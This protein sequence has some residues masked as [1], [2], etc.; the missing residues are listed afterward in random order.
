[1]VEMSLDEIR[2]HRPAGDRSPGGTGSDAPPEDG[3]GPWSLWLG[4]GVRTDLAERLLSG[5][6]L[7]GRGRVQRELDDLADLLRDD[8][9]PGRLLVGLRSVPREDLGILRRFLDQDPARELV[10]LDDRE[11][12]AP[13]ALLCLPRTRLLPRPLTTELV[14][15]LGTTPERLGETPA[16]PAPADPPPA[17]ATEV[18]EHERLLLAWQVLRDRLAGREDL[19][20]LLGRL[21]VELDRSLPADGDERDDD[22]R[23]DL[24]TLAEELLAGLSLDRERRMRFLFRPEGELSLRGRRDE[25]E[26]ILADLFELVGRCSSPD[27]V[28]RVRVT[29]TSGGEADPDAPVDTTVEFPDAPLVGLPP[30]DELD[31]EVLA[32]RFGPEVSAV[33]RRLLAATGRQEGELSSQPARAGRR[34]L[35]LRLPRLLGATLA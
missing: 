16:A 19:A 25:L 5:P 30:G 7:A 31:P 1:M 21:E 3:A 17:P 9:G 22:A 10:V 26:R 8:V 28:V 2:P 20:P 11:G 29:S 4:P 33:L 13:G 12:Q 18:P 35:R 23:I 24:G 27:S 34:Q 14:A 15:W 32:G 6:G